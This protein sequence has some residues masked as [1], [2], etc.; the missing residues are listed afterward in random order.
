MTT[1]ARRPLLNHVSADG[2]LPGFMPVAIAWHTCPCVVPLVPFYACS[3]NAFVVVFARGLD[4]APGGR[5]KREEQVTLR[6]LQKRVSGNAQ[7]YEEVMR[8]A[9]RQSSTT[10]AVPVSQPSSTPGSKRASA[11]C[12]T[13]PST[14]G[15]V[16]PTPGAPGEGCRYAPASLQ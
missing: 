15:T 10:G 4:L 1:V 14:P 5:K 9:K 3:L 6:E 13:V 11:H 2:T 16:P 7:D 12:P 8:K